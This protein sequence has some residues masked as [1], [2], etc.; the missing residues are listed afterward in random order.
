MS[1]KI[2]DCYAPYV[3]NF[4]EDNW[5]DFVDKLAENYGEDDAEE[6]AEEIVKA[7]I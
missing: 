2:E 5:N 4:L 1:K 6:I 7:L 3:R